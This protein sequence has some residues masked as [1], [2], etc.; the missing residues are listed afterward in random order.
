MEVKVYGA[1]VGAGDEAEYTGCEL[2]GEEKEEYDV[3]P[4]IW[5][6]GVSLGGIGLG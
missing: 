2:G 6:C 3:G 1:V 5:H 4:E